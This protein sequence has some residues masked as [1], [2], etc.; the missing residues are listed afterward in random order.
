M[1]KT[2]KR[3]KHGLPPFLEFGIC[4]FGHPG[5][6]TDNLADFFSLDEKAPEI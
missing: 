4:T 5:R 6:K 1:H 3:G 2:L